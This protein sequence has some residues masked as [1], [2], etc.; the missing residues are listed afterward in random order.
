MKVENIFIVF[1]SM[2]LFK[3]Q[4]ELFPN[5]TFI[6]VFESNYQKLRIS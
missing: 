3:L 6:Q 4:W 1:L 2:K 5:I